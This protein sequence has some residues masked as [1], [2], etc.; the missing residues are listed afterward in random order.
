R[1]RLELGAAAAKVDVV[2]DFDRVARNDHQTWAGAAFGFVRPGRGRTLV[3]GI[4]DAVRVGIGC[5][6]F[7]AGVDDRWLGV[8]IGFRRDRARR[9]L[10]LSARTS[11]IR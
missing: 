7:G 6:H 1:F 9:A 2:A 5:R 10:A 11:T 4:R 3:E 8:T